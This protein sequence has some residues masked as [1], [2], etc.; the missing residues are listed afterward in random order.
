MNFIAKREKTGE[1]FAVNS[2]SRG[3]VFDILYVMPGVTYGEAFFI[4]EMPNPPQDTPVKIELSTS[5]CQ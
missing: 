1:L 4:S 5:R 3:R 2:E